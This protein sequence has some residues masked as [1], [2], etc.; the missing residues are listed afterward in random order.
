MFL[1]EKQTYCDVYL[2]ILDLVIH[3]QP[4]WTIKNIFFFSSFFISPFF[5]WTRTF[6]LDYARVLLFFTPTDSQGALFLF[7]ERLLK[8]TES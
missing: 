4:N 8:G 1:K 3:A 7:L 6:S 2:K 5:C